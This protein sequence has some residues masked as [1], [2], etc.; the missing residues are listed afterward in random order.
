MYKQTV[1]K[2]DVF[3]YECSAY[4]VR[5]CGQAAW[6]MSI[7]GWNSTHNVKVSKLNASHRMTVQYIA[8]KQN[9]VADKKSLVWLIYS[10]QSSEFFYSV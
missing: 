6:C 5:Q 10:T 1:N 9:C 7:I 2:A 3:L 4:I 8:E